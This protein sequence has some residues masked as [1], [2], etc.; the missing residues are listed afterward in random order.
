M[1]LIDA[2]AI[3]RRP[4]AQDA[5]VTRVSLAC[6]FTPLHLETHLLA[7]LKLR[8]PDREVVLT[9]GLYGDLVGNLERLENDVMDACIVVEWADLDPRLGLRSL[10]GW[11]PSS[12]SDILSTAESRA[13]RFGESIARLERSASVAVSLPTLPLPPIG[14]NPGWCAGKFE[15][16]LRATLR[17]LTER[18]SSACIVS[19]QRLD[20]T[21][22]PGNRLDVASEFQTGF[23]YTKEHAAV[24]G[25]LLARALNPPQ[26]KKGIISDLDDTLWKGVVGEIGSAEVA[27]DLNGGAQIHGLYQQLLDSLAEA[28]T[29]LAIASKNDPAVVEEAL[30][31]SDLALHRDRLFPVEVNWKPKSESVARILSAWN[32]SADSVV[33]VDDSPMELA[34]VKRVFPEITTMQFTAQDTRSAWTML[35]EL[36]DLFGKSALNAEDALRISSLRQGP[37]FMQTAPSNPTAARDFLTSLEAVMTIDASKDPPPR[38]AYELVN[39]TNQFNM[40]GVRLSWGEWCTFLAGPDRFQ[41]LIG[42]RDK[43]GPLGGIAVVAGERKG[44]TVQLH[45]WVMSC[46]A[47]SRDIEH[48]SLRRLFESLDVDEVVLDVAETGRNGPFR[49]FLRLYAPWPEAGPARILREAFDARCPALSIRAQEAEIAGPA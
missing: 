4:A 46:R 49:E 20:T 13:Q 15:L 29:L 9:S 5:P 17:R 26:P 24:L 12:L 34:E 44:R 2:L 41:W 10:G 45:N 21:S 32:V 33:F 22:P 1:K 38:R 42:Y 23:P 18:T 25:E 14:F 8:R 11:R 27:W 37:E 47:F 3:S 7:H 40:N 31:R 16:E 36:R 19:Q 43:Y 35:E 28:G 39:K 6:G 30:A 48:A